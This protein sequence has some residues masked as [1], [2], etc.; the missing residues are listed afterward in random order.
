MA[1]VA[2]NPVN[3]NPG[4]NDPILSESLTT[5]DDQSLTPL[6][7]TQ[8]AQQNMGLATGSSNGLVSG[9]N[10]DKLS[11]L[12]TQAQFN[13]RISQLTDIALPI[14][15]GAP[16]DGSIQIYQHIFLVPWLFGAAWTAVAAGST[17]LTVTKNGVA[18]PGFT[19]ISITTTPS[20]WAPSG[21][22]AAYT[23][24]DGDIMGL[25]FAGTTG[26]C[27]NMRFSLGVNAQIAS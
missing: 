24:N 12:E 9:P 18:I 19:A 6:V 25:T 1:R 7:I 27:V 15:I 22:T 3:N 2:D 5:H 21:P 10:G 16:V 13:I 4:A 20:I 23:F 14:F 26:N 11:G 17:N 8:F